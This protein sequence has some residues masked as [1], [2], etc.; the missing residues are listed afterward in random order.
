MFSRTDAAAPSCVPADP[1]SRV[2]THGFGR[3]GRR[4]TLCSGGREGTASGTARSPYRT[5][6]GRRRTKRV[7]DFGREQSCQQV[8]LRELIADRLHVS[9]EREFFLLA[10]I[11]GDLP[12]AV[13]AVPT[14]SV[15]TGAGGGFEAPGTDEESAPLQFSLAGVQLKLSMIREGRGLT[16]PAGGSG[17]D[18]IVKLPG[19]QYQGVP[20]NEFVTMSWARMVEASFNEFIRAAAREILGLPPTGTAAAWR[21]PPPTAPPQSELVLGLN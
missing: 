5:P 19:T 13:R 20:E 1:E 8:E 4:G 2:V 10:W 15:D 12:G 7:R 3:A 21:R 17:G 16:L 9:P 11:G 14:A 6:T 18:W